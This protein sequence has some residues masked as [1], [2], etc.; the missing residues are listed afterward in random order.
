MNF[1]SDYGF[2]VR[3][4]SDRVASKAD[5]CVPYAL[6]NHVPN[7]ATADPFGSE[8]VIWVDAG[9]FRYHKHGV[10]F[11]PFALGCYATRGARFPLN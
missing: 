2:K 9:L 10:G 4:A 7:A 8:Q 6:P 5:Q 3:S 11:N 1:F